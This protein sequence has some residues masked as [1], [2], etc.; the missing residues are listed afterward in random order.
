MFQYI[1]HLFSSD[2][3]AQSFSPSH[4]K[5]SGTQ[6]VLLSQRWWQPSISLE[7]SSSSERSWQSYWPSHTLA[8]GM[9][10]LPW[11]HWN[12]SGTEKKS[13]LW[14]TETVYFWSWLHIQP[15]QTCF[16]L[17][18]TPVFIRSILTVLLTITDMA[19]QDTVQSVFTELETFATLQGFWSRVEGFADKIWFLF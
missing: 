13:E 1:P 6:R 10:R 14:R 2:P 4:R 7:Q 8:D 5:V 12:S 17:S 9:H 11:E 3:S 15:R 19:V 16:A 18:S